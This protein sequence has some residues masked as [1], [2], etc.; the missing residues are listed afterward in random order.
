MLNL[1]PKVVWQNSR[2]L[3][4]LEGKTGNSAFYADVFFIYQFRDFLIFSQNL[5]LTK[6]V[7]F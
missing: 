2:C 7:A 4:M 6:Y 1:Q 3:V 5:K